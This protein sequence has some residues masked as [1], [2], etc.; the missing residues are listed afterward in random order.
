MGNRLF[1]LKSRNETGTGSESSRRRS[2]LEDSDVSATQG[3]K[4]SRTQ[5]LTKGRAK[6]LGSTLVR[7]CRDFPATVTFC[8]IWIVV[9]VAMTYT[10]LAAGN[11]L[12]WF[13]WLVPGFGNGHRFGDLTLQDLG[14]G[15][16]WRLVTCNFV[17]YSLLHIVLNL[18][19]MYQLGTRV[20]S[21]YGSPQLVLIYGLTG[22][23]GNLVSALIR[24]GI[25][26][27][28]V[29]HSGGGSVVILGLVGLCAVAGW[30]SR[31]RA[32]RRLGRQMTI[33]LI[34]TALIGMLL[35]NFLDN[36]GH[37]GGAL[38][39]AVLGLAHSRFLGNV[40]RPSAWGSGVVTGLLMA[41]C[42]VAQLIDDHWEATPTHVEKL[43]IHRLIVLESTA[44][45]LTELGRVVRQGDSPSLI[46]QRWQSLGRLLDGQAGA[47]VR[48]LRPLVERA[49]DGPLSD[50]QR[51]DFQQRLMRLI[52]QARGEQQLVQRWLWQ[53]RHDPRFAPTRP[54]PPGA[55]RRRP[56]PAAPNH[57]RPGRSSGARQAGAAAGRADPAGPPRSP[58]SSGPV[59]RTR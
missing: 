53:L 1:F 39:G 20:E 32:R 17:H 54:R 16:V 55:R 48:G 13:R 4:A 31:R 42:G 24:Y 26:A 23:G 52:Q 59:D 36:W 21:W 15:E 6:G 22:A 40:S 18:L 8:L 7:E 38:V 51:R 2:R 35:P 10:Y 19:V 50:P 45:A 49:R 25:G 47:D 46:T 28:R 3:R 43:L 12:P 57:F 58:G 27:N 29:V 34:L 37:A 33:F 5:G 30:R 41:A 14:Q 9:F 11:S 44:W 56:E